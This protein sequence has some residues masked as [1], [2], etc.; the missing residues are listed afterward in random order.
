MR[1]RQYYITYVLFP[2]K[3]IEKKKLKA[4]KSEITL[5]GDP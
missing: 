5:K 2:K 1:Q 4:T 3:K